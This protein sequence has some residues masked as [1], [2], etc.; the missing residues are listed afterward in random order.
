MKRTV[1]LIWSISIFVGAIA[2]Q[3]PTAPNISAVAAAGQVSNGKYS[4]SLLKLTVEAPNGTL[5]INP[6]VN[7]EQGRAR[8]LQ[9][10]SKPGAWE[11]TY[12]FAVLVDTLARYPQLQSP[13]QYVRSVR[14]QLETEGLATLREEFPLSIRGVQFTGAIMQQEVDGKKHCR[15]LYTTFRDGLIISFDVEA[16]TEEKLNSLV[17]RAVNLGN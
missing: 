6:L 12:T 14:H 17:T 16:T 4:N 3:K 15:G 2:A 11:D 8:L 7:Q 9:I 13:A 10:L 1:S 5:Q